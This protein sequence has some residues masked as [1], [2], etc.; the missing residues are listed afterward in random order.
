MPK[1]AEVILSMLAGAII[2]LAMMVTL[3]PS[4]KAPADHPDITIAT[5]DKYADAMKTQPEY[6]HHGMC[7]NE[8]G[9]IVG[10]K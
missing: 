7:V 2:A 4:P 8:N 3:A 6:I 1:L 5:C 9:V 10:A